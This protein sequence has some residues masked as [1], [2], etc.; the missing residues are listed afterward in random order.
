VSAAD[1][2]AAREA[3]LVAPAHVTSAPWVKPLKV[4]ASC[5]GRYGRSD[6][7]GTGRRA[8]KR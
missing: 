4:G 5:V 8:L 3:E 7:V 6:F 2:K 1:V